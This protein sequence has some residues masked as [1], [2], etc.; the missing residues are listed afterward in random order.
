MRDV[1]KLPARKRALVHKLVNA[2][3]GQ[4][5]QD[6]MQPV[7]AGVDGPSTLQVRRQRH[8]TAESPATLACGFPLCEILRHTI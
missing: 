1:A 5:C 2:R 4:P 8:L 6:D 7:I 3:V